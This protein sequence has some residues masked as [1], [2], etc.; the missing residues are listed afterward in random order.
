MGATMCGERVTN[1]RLVGCYVR[2]SIHAPGGL[3]YGIRERTHARDLIDDD[4][5]VIVRIVPK[6]S[7]RVFALRLHGNLDAQPPPRKPQRRKSLSTTYF[8]QSLIRLELCAC[9]RA[10]MF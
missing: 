7:A 1:V 5:D 6:F 4:D 9:T 10:C 3:L 2:L 8:V